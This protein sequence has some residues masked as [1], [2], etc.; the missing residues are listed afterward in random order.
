MYDKIISTYTKLGN[1]ELAVGM[2]A[3]M[4]DQFD[5]FGVKSPDRKE[6]NKVFFKEVKLLSR[7]EVFELTKKLWER[8]E[9]EMHYLGQEL[10]DKV[11]K[12][13]ITNKADIKFLE[14]LILNNSWW[15]TVDFVAPRLMKTYFE[16][17]PEERNKK[18]DEWIA[19]DNIWLKR[20]A[21]LIHLKM[22]NKVDLPYMFETI[23]RLNGTKEF[24]INKAI[25]WVLR[26]HSK[27]HKVE[28]Q[29]FIDAHGKELSNLSFKEGTKYL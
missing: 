5:F 6:I 17:F 2:K 13:V 22:A 1:P 9:R 11:G 12:K 8:P 14:Y 19:S 21:L 23:L 4:R 20:S 25:G 18:V 16:K 10:M 26:E 3:Y 24:F 27:K 29:K 28:I 15:D 7:D